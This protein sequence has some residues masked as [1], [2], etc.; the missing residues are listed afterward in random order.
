MH[1]YSHKMDTTGS[2]KTRLSDF[3]DGQ[4]SSI[5]T[6]QFRQY[7]RANVLQQQNST[8]A[9]KTTTATTTTTTITT[10]KKNNYNS[11]HLV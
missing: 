5:R 1:N 4:T 7:T 2:N 10:S 9:T 11:K 6:I 3:S 8:A